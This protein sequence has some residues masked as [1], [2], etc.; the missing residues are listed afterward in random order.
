MRSLLVNIWFQVLF[1]SPPG[2]LFT[3][4][5]RY[6]ALSVTKSYLALRDGPRIFTPDSTCPVLLWI[7][8]ICFS[9]RLRDYYPMLCSFPT[10]FVYDRHSMT[11]S[12]PLRYYYHR[13]GLLPFRSPLLWESLFTFFSSRY[14]DVSVP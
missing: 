7:P 13:F 11:R 5:S 10:I 8:L 2:V 6:Y 3:V 4:P 14:L 12:V 1:H 9:F